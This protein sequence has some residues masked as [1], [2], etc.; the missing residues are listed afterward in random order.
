M[1][2]AHSRISASSCELMKIL[3]K[4]YSFFRQAIF[5]EI[6]TILIKYN[7]QAVI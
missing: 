7:D 6:L 2:Q 1:Q 5:C 4:N 3:V